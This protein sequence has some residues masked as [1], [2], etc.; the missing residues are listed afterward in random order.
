MKKQELVDLIMIHQKQQTIDS[1]VK[2][3]NDEPS[4]EEVEEVEVQDVITEV[5]VSDEV[6]LSNGEIVDIE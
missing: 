3:D 1:V 6:E 4:E 5:N 2:V